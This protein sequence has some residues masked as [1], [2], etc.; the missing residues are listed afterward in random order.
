[1]SA[2]K[3]VAE[4]EGLI[5][6]GDLEALQRFTPLGFNWNQP[7]DNNGLLLHEAIRFTVCNL[8]SKRQ[9]YLQIIEWMLASGADPR[10]QNACKGT[11]SLW[12]ESEQEETMIRISIHGRSAMSYTL[13]ML[14]AMREGKGGAD[15]SEEC[16]YL[17]EVIK[18]LAKAL[19]QNNQKIAVHRG[20]MDM[21]E[22]VRDMTSTHNVIFEAADGEVSAHDHVLVAASPVLKAMLGSTMR[23]GESRRIP[24]KDSTSSDVS[25]LVDMM[26]TSSTCKDPDYKT[27]L[28]VLDLAHRWQVHYLVHIL[29]DAL[30]PETLGEKSVGVFEILRLR[31]RDLGRCLILFA[32][33]QL[34]KCQVSCAIFALKV[35]LS[36]A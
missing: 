4:V 16:E 6:L 8:E 19:P 1:M 22:S 21:W 36:R 14:H 13:A 34:L 15:W 10:K 23:E 27:L 11:T 9:Q 12:Q 2:G 24:V 5:F 3:D 31:K 33:E 30:Q 32:R 7:T 17:E 20:L 28:N 25:L 29:A 18:L 26:Y 35:W